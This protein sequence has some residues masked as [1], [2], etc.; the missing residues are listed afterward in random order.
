MPHNRG[1]A[2]VRRRTALVSAESGAAPSRPVGQGLLC[3][4]YRAVNMD[5]FAGPPR[6]QWKS[7]RW[8]CIPQLP[9]ANSVPCLPLP[10]HSHPPLHAL[11]N[12]AVSCCLCPLPVHALHARPASQAVL[13]S[14]TTVHRLT[15]LPRLAWPADR[16]PSL[17]TRR[18]VPGRSECRREC[19]A[20][21]VNSQSAML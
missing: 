21:A 11:P 14:T 9:E 2:G 20:E 4:V 16:G 19:E 12:P 7:T 10:L 3:A 1:Q 18:A 6:A 15:P 8:Q 13:A 5:L 17:R